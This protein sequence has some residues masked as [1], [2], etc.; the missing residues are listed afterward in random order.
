MANEQNPALTPE[1]E[2]FRKKFNVRI[3]KSEE[4]GTSILR[5]PEGVYGY[6]TAPAS[7]E[8]PTFASP[9]YRCTELIRTGE[10]ILMLGYLNPNEADAVEAGQEPV[11]ATLYPEPYEQATRLVS[12][13][14]SRIDRRR[15]PTRDEGN[16]MKIDVGPKA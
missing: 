1:R 7:D 13:P 12:I 10:E 11:A 16:S 9:V 15:P 4:E 5:L 8:M 2:A 14:V 3:V 6:T